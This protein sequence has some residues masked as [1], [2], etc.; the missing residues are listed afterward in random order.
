MIGVI[1]YFFTNGKLFLICEEDT[2]MH[3]S[4]FVKLPGSLH[5]YLQL[6]SSPLFRVTTAM[7]DG[8]ANTRDRDLPL[9]THVTALAQCWAVPRAGP[10][11]PPIARRLCPAGGVTGADWV[12]AAE[13]NLSLRNIPKEMF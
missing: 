7:P 8:C 11:C 2:N 13:T 5:A 6:L 4:L 9:H 10:R 12:P 1:N 3:L